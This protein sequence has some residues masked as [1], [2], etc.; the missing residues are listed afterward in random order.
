M[1]KYPKKKAN[2]MKKIEDLMR[3]KNLTKLMK[4]ALLE[5]YRGRPVNAVDKSTIK[6]L[7][8]RELIDVEITSFGKRTAISMM[9]L[10]IQCE[11]LSLELETIKLIYTGRPESALLSYYKSRGYVGVSC[12]SIG[13]FTVLKALMLNKLVKYN[14][15]GER[16]DAITRGLQA[17]FVI[18]TSNIDEIILEISSVT[19]LEYMQNFKEIIQLDILALDHPELS[20]EFASA[21]YDSISNDLFIEVARKISESPYD[22][23]NGWPDLTLIKDKT[24]LFVEV[25]TSDKLHESQLITIPIMNHILPFKFSVCKLTKCSP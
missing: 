5:I 3:F 4:R 21:M 22:Y 17:Q 1:E 25:K 19:K 2:N 11:E 16:E 15:F 23:R 7:R 10:K 9:P 20:L 8:R 12:E 13:I 24:V 6:A 18:L 14:S